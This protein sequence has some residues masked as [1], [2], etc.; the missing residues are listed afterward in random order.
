MQPSYVV[1][2]ACHPTEVV[3]SGRRSTKAALT[4]AVT[5]ILTFGVASGVG[6]TQTHHAAITKAAAANQYIALLKAEQPPSTAL[7]P[8]RGKIPT[9]GKK[10]EAFVQPAIATLTHFDAKLLNEKWPSGD[11]ADIKA[12]ARDDAHVIADLRKLANI[13]AHNTSTFYR[14]LSRDEQPAA[15]AAAVVR[16]DI[17]LPPILK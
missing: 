7:E 6:A 12:E 3:N 9:S 11:E 1:T 15:T 2:W 5:A 16:S 4:V 10:A 17:G 13:N 14:T 8:I